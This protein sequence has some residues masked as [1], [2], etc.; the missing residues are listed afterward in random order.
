MKK[1]LFILAIALPCLAQAKQR[2]VF[3]VGTDSCGS[4]LIALE[5][6]KPTTA[7]EM[8]GQVYF[9]DAATY[10]QW[11]SGYV[12]SHSTVYGAPSKDTDFNGMVM[13]VKKYCEEHP[14]D[15]IIHAADA[16]IKAHFKA[17]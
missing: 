15:M 11:V 12:S 14:S 16:F 1:I 17:R 4:M 8:N 9:S 2:V 13:W 10:S 7:I 3:G 6:N 5:K